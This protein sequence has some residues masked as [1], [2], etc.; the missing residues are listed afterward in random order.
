MMFLVVG[1]LATAAP[2]RC[3]LDQAVQ[4]PNPASAAVGNTSAKPDPAEESAGSAS[5]DV[6]H[7]VHSRHRTNETS[8]TAATVFSP[9]HPNRPCGSRFYGLGKKRQSAAPRVRTCF[10]SIATLIAG[11]FKSVAS[12]GVDFYI[13]R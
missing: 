9:V 10:W 12:S 5:T 2:F 4:T 13:G 6:L 7:A 8:L 11:V 1:E 3:Q